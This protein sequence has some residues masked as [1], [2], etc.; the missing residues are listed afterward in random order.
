MPQKTSEGIGMFFRLFGGSVS[1]SL[2]NE[3]LENAFE[4]I[5]R[6]NGCSR[7]S[8]HDRFEFII[9]GRL[10]N[11]IPFIFEHVEDVISLQTEF[12]LDRFKEVP[13]EFEGT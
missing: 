13:E 3:I 12:R 8:R 10:A 4:E 6:Y 11:F 7:I 2:I 1:T 5:V 9:L